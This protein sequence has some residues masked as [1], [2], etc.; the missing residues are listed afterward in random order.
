MY[1][2]FYEIY[3]PDA[4]NL[5]SRDSDFHFNNCPV[6]NPKLPSRMRTN[7]NECLLDTDSKTPKMHF[8]KKSCKI[9][10]CTSITY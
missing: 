3:V 2:N 6:R 1:V 9:V 10:V 5:N 4:L 7:Y 8:R